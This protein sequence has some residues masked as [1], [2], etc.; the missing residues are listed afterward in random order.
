MPW[1]IAEGEI[2]IAVGKIYSPDRIGVA[3]FAAWKY[4]GL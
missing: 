2:A 3:T 4:V 1:A